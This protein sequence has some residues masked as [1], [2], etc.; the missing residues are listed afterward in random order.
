MT[1]K[2]DRF[3]VEEKTCFDG[4]VIYE[5]NDN[6]L[7]YYNFH[8]N[9]LLCQWI[10]NKLN[11]LNNRNMELEQ[12]VEDWEFANRTEMAHH[13]VEENDLQDKINSLREERR[14]LK[15]I[16]E[17]L[18]EYIK[19]H[20]NEDIVMHARNLMDNYKLSEWSEDYQEWRAN[21]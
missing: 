6:D 8:E 5:L 12:E 21:L 16:A 7:S 17:S 14:Q 3:K 2:K 20:C 9:K 1:E 19:V 18:M 13:R 4:N 11:D 15:I 10:C